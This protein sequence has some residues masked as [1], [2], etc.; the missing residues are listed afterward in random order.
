MPRAATFGSLRPAF[1][2]LPERTSMPPART[3][4][5]DAL[6]PTTGAAAG[7]IARG[8]LAPQAFVSPKYLYDALGS[9]LFEAITALPEYYPTRTEKAILERCIG[10]VAGAAGEGGTLVE[11]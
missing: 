11:L 4:A 10:A 1:F 3:A 9:R 2:H 8:L 6:A 5:L 7:E